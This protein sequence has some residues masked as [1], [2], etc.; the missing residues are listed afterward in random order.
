M[1]REGGAIV[2]RRGEGS[3][4]ERGNGQMSGGEG[5]AAV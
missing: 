4:D 2:W 3:S 1:L 5:R